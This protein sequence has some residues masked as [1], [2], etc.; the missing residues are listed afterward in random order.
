M[1]L[2][3]MRKY[4]LFLILPLLFI[5]C[6][7][8]SDFYENWL[9]PEYIST[10]SFLQEGEDPEIYYSTDILSDIYFLRSNYF[11]ILGNSSYNGPAD[12]SVEDEI[13]TLCRETGAKIALYTTQYTD[14]RTGVTGYNGYVS[15]Y[16]IK[17]Y[18]YDIFLFVP[19][20][21]AEILYYGRIGLSY[22]DL[23][24]SE[25][26]AARQNTG[27]SIDV[28]YQDSPAFYANLAPGDV[29]TEV[30]GIA[31]YDSNVLDEVFASLTSEDKVEIKFIRDG[32]AQVTNLQPLL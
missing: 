1:Q 22:S 26:I 16:S 8:V 31:I 28:V 19:M 9:P 30:N 32:F 2:I 12:D 17:R 6:S 10:E 14:T 3:K 4:I 15:S 29:I 23:T 13:D 18:D 20:S 5:G 21:P 11:L 27:A 7:T 24:S 25:R